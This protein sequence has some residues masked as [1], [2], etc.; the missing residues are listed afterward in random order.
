MPVDNDD[1]ATIK[2]FIELATLTRIY[3]EFFMIP[4][5]EYTGGYFLKEYGRL[6]AALSPSAYFQHVVRRVEQETQRLKDC[7]PDAPW[8]GVLTVVDNRL[9]GTKLQDE[10]FLLQGKKLFLTRGPPI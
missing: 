8:D 5:E 7:C 4:Y 9:I 3:R 6:N 10:N 1:R 2:L